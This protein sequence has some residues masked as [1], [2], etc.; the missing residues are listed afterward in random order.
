M[1]E[2]LE[3][4]GHKLA[5]A[6]ELKSVVRTMK[7]ISI[8][9]ILQYERAVQSLDTYFW[10]IQLGFFVCNGQTGDL[11]I[12]EPGQDGKTGAIVF[13]A[14]QGLVGQFNDSLC[15][16][17]A[18]DLEEVL[19]EKTVWAI[20]SSLQSRLGD[21]GLPPVQQFEVPNTVEAI[22]PLVSKLLLE[23]EQ[24]LANRGFSSIY[25]YNNRLHDGLTYT[26]NKLR[27]FPLDEI[28]LKELT[29]RQW[30]SNKL[31]EAP[32]GKELTLKALI[33]EYLFVSLFRACAESLASENTSRLAAMQRAE[34]N[35][36]ELLAELTYSYHQ[37]RQRNIDE[38][39][40]DV[41]FGSE[42]MKSQ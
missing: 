24:T 17:V 36:K 35:I 40:F 41:I 16:F 39:M 2:T 9:S 23:I 4:L 37:L 28:W 26:P 31:P 25:L 8:S 12:M 42:A 21:V 10:N 5:M 6:K 22:I 11:K 15:R 33:R 20:G 3:S 30:P 32:N 38:E 13:G 14:G 29:A 18:A 34:K 19:G 7:A 1:K 27:F